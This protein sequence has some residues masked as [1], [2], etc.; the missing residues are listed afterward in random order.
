MHNT[1]A[2]TDIKMDINYRNGEQKRFTNQIS[3]LTLTILRK[4]KKKYG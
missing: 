1:R 4:R 2:R 3:F